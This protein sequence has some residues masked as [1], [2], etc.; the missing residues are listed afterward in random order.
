MF[1]SNN[2]VQVKSFL[3]RDQEIKVLK[4]AFPFLVFTPRSSMKLVVSKFEEKWVS[5]YISLHLTSYHQLLGPHKNVSSIKWII[6]FWCILWQSL[7]RN[8]E[9]QLYA[10]RIMLFTLD[11]YTFLFIKREFFLIFDL[12]QVITDMSYWKYYDTY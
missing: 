8:L 7:S 3:F 4:F 11:A 5:T 9:F 6:T 1:P 12:F 10:S 2:V